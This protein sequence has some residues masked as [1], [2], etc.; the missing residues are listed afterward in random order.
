M[1][2]DPKTECPIDGTGSS[3]KH[4][5]GAQNPDKDK[6]G[7]SK[8][9]GGC[10][11]TPND[12]PATIP[13]PVLNEPPA[14]TDTPAPDASGTGTSTDCNHEHDLDMSE[15]PGARHLVIK[16]QDFAVNPMTQQSMTSYL[17]L[18]AV[19]DEMG[20]DGEDK[21]LAEM[22]KS[23]RDDE[24][25]R[26]DYPLQNDYDGVTVAQRKAITNR[27]H[28]LGG[29]RD[30][31]DGNRI[32]TTKGDKVEVI[33]GNYK[34]LV[35][36]RQDKADN[37][38]DWEASGGQIVDDDL[39]PGAITDI[40]WIKD[41]FTG[42]WRVY[43][44]S[45]KG[46][47]VTRYHGM[48]REEFLGSLQESIV[49]DE[50]GTQPTLPDGLLEDQE[51][52]Y[53]EAERTQGTFIQ[54]EAAT[55]GWTEPNGAFVLN[56]IIREKKWARSMEYQQGSATKPI[57]RIV[58]RT[59]AKKMVSRTG[60][61]D[62]WV[63]RI[64]SSTYGTTISEETHADDLTE[65]RTVKSFFGKTTAKVGGSSTEH[66]FGAF[67]EMFIGTH[68]SFRVGAP[69]IEVS[70]GL[71]A[72]AFLGPAA[73]V[74][75]GALFE[76]SYAAKAEVAIGPHVEVNFGLRKSIG[77]THETG[78]VNKWDKSLATKFDFLAGFFG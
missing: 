25:E 1:K 75:L 48:V 47:V 50:H 39:A 21:R 20:P 17:R 3:K 4:D 29:W 74:F 59:W 41:E 26:T 71:S 61:S 46:D 54:T 13:T 38:A 66:W 52:V 67:I 5:D 76:F 7:P 42:T 43:E 73:Q 72:E 57:E 37:A 28:T 12:P 14:V 18:G 56:P 34:M 55:E 51:A 77:T 69:N 70:T 10:D 36:G 44:E 45:S 30:H 27:L 49:G 11:G 2:N 32:S 22:V 40:R 6:G 78:T 24:R 33:R 8:K 63:E 62:K 23:F 60:S 35:L 19:R 31:S 68:V 15:V 16:V 9:D 64:D 58:E 53:T 65:E